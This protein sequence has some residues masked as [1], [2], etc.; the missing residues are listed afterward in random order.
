M[1]QVIEIKDNITY[2][3]KYVFISFCPGNLILDSV[4]IFHMTKYHTLKN[5]H[6]NRKS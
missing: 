2:S 4:S 3:K 1:G 5:I 6:K